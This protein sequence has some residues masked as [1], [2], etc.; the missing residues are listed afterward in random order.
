MVCGIR[1]VLGAIVALYIFICHADRALSRV[2]AWK[3]SVS[4]IHEERQ[5][6]GQRGNNA[7]NKFSGGVVLVL[8]RLDSRLQL[9]THWRRKH[10]GEMTSAHG[11]VWVTIPDLSSF[12]TSFQLPILILMTN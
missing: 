6:V 12:H 2:G 8:S 7:M 11:S 3:E 1:S 9:L 5:D 4:R 10:D